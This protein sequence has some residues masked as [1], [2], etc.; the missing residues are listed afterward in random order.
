[1]SNVKPKFQRNKIFSLSRFSSGSAFLEVKSLGSQSSFV[2]ISRRSSE[3]KFHISLEDKLQMIRI[4][5]IHSPAYKSAHDC[6][7]YLYLE[8]IRYSQLARSHSCRLSSWDDSS[9]NTPSRTV[10]S[11][12][13]RNRSSTGCPGISAENKATTA[14]PR[15][16]RIQ[17]WTSTWSCWE[18][19]LYFHLQKKELISVQHKIVLQVQCINHI[20]TLITPRTP[21]IGQVS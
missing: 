5:F 20:F 10:Y 14:C 21:I 3:T 17:L 16:T 13:L 4:F 19:S 2:Q 1:M 6:S 11:P 15:T 18:P 7:P 8:Q 12:C 9:K